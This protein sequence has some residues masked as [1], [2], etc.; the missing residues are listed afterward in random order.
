MVKCFPMI[1]IYV[2]FK[3]TG[4]SSPIYAAPNI[5]KASAIAGIRFQVV[6]CHLSLRKGLVSLMWSRVR[7][8]L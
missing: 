5:P 4:I 7:G 2:K 6:Y 8:C 3:G 1:K